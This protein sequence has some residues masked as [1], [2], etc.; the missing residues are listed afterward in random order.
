MLYSRTLSIHSICNL[1]HLLTQNSQ[2]SPSL[3]LH[4][5]VAQPCPTLCNPTDCSSPGSSVHGEFSSQEDWSRLQCP[6]PGDL[7]NPGMEPRSPALQVNSLPSEPPGKPSLNF[8]I[9]DYITL[10]FI[11]LN[12]TK[13]S[14]YYIV[15]RG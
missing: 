6:P 1:L 8:F 4:V 13:R 2:S 3:L 7:L 5:K 12:L 15:L 9:Q 11:S 14:I 10:K